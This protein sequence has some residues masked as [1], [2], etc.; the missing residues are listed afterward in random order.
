MA[1]DKISRIFDEVF[2]RFTENDIRILREKREKAQ[3]VMEILEKHGIYAVA[4][5]SIARGDVNENS[6]VDI[7]VLDTIAPYKIESVLESAGFSIYMKKIVQA[8]PRNAPKGYIILDP[9]EELVISFP[10]VKLSKKEIEFY[11]F[12]GIVNL[13]ELK[14]QT[15]KPGVNKKLLLVVPKDNGYTMSSILGRE[16]EVASLLGI[17]IETVKERI[18]VLS[19]RDE[20]GRTGVFVNIELAP[21]ESFEDALEK[22]SSKNPVFRRTLTNGGVL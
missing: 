2:I 3:K 20:I 22:E 18:A 14:R 21:D 1:R 5:G 6:D 16:S 15:R 7:V 17:S 11:S 12:G 13:L 8:T 10:F 9:R 19:R 4:H